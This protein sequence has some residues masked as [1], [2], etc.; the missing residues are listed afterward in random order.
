[1]QSTAWAYDI[2]KLSKRFSTIGINHFNLANM[3]ACNNVVGR[4]NGCRD[5]CI[6]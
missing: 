1:M 3:I 6:V 5:G 4:S 2:S